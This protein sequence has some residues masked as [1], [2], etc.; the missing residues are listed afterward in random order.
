MQLLSHL[1]VA[2]SH[3]PTAIHGRHQATRPCPLTRFHERTLSFFHELRVAHWLHGPT[4]HF[5]VLCSSECAALHSRL[6]RSMCHHIHQQ[7]QMRLSPLLACVT[8]LLLAMY[9]GAASGS[10]TCVSEN[11][12]LSLPFF[13]CS[14]SPHPPHHLPSPPWHVL[15]FWFMVVHFSSSLWCVAASQ[16]EGEREG[17]EEGERLRCFVVVL[18]CTVSLDCCLDVLC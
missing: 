16:G 5:F 13:C 2:A 4:S 15:W 9:S 7:Q 1:C 18:C 8:A 3:W 11:L 6:L 10:R 17:G 12:C 14:L